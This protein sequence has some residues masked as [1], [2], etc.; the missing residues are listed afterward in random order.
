MVVVVVVVVSSAVAGCAGAGGSRFQA[1]VEE[2]EGVGRVCRVVAR[3]V[4][5]R[6][7]VIGMIV[8]TNSN[9]KTQSINSV[10]SS[11]EL[12]LNCPPTHCLS[13][14]LPV[15]RSQLDCQTSGSLP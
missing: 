11:E 8:A 13:S 6:D 14:P 3:V 9:R 4:V 12:L 7:R 15:S 2:E 1:V 10:V 5:E